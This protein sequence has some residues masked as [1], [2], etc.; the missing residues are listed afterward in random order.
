MIYLEDLIQNDYVIM[1]ISEI[2]RRTEVKLSRWF[3]RTSVFEIFRQ[4]FMKLQPDAAA[5]MSAMIGMPDYTH[6]YGDFSK[7]SEQERND[8]SAIVASA[9]FE[10]YMTARSQGFFIG[11]YGE[12][13]F[14]FYL[15][16][17]TTNAAFLQ[18]D[19]IVL[20]RVLQ[21]PKDI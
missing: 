19:K 5:C 7:L 18:I 17:L 15:E 4:I 20:E 12:S 6:M 9:G 2:F 21:Q 16:Q 14:P 13:S 11:Q 10:I 8:I 1:D 3:D